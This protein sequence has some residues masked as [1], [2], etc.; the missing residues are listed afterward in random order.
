MQSLKFKRIV[1]VSDTLKSAN[2]FKFQKRFNLI[3]GNKNSVG[4]STIVKCIYWAIGC[5]PGFDETWKS[6]DC[7]VLLE[8]SINEK[9]FTVL[10]INNAILFSYDGLNFVRYKKITEEFSKKF[11]EI[12]GFKVKLPKRG[13]EP[14][15]EN[16]PPSYYFLPFYIDQLRS[17]SRPWDSFLKLT[18]YA[19]WQIPIV[20]YHTGYLSPKHFEIEEQIFDYE[21]EK[22]DANEEIR[23]I[24]TALEI[25]EKY[26]PKSSIA[27]TDDEF[28]VLNNELR[29]ELEEL[30]IAQENYLSKLNDAKSTKYHLENQLEIAKR[31]VIEIDKDYQFSVENVEFDELEC[32]LCGTLHDNSLISRASILSDKQQAEDQV[33]IISQE[34]QSLDIKIEELQPQF[35]IVRKRISEINKKYEKHQNEDTR[36]NFTDLVDG[37]A[38]KSVQRNVKDSKTQ[39]QALYKELSDKQAL[40]K[41]SQKKLLTRDKKQTLDNLFIDNLTRFIEK[42]GAKGINLNK[43]KNPN[44]YN[45][46]CG[47]GGAAEGTRALLAYQI[48]IYN[49]IIYSKNEV[50]A[51]FVVDTPNQH[52]QDDTSYDKI[53]KII[54]EDIPE[55]YQVILCGMNNP[56]LKSFSQNSNV[57]HLDE[58]KLLNTKYYN[59]LNKEITVI[60][61]SA[62]TFTPQES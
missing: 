4:K 52:E 12:V 23:R 46:L 40:L 58:K 61:L 50:V 18:H 39:K 37:L 30:S 47:S 44:D 10:R 1:L 59:D 21:G 13:E 28:E 56:G 20:K 6:F 14:V 32:P 36:Q 31:A 2:Q 55:N 35:D 33:E 17:W 48:A 62:K 60:I 51:P 57:I 53:V 45:R 8:F 16:P 42:L 19:K 5:D 43:I 38:S 34:I 9:N 15:L 49:Q 22:K 3:T 25:V 54:M 24:D 7:K 41:K 11:A 29:G 26:I 27:I